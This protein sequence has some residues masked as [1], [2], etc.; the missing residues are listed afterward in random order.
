MFEPALGRLA[1]VCGLVVH[2]VASLSVRG[3]RSRHCVRGSSRLLAGLVRSL[4]D[5]WRSTD[6]SRFIAFALVVS[7]WPVAVFL[8]VS[9]PSDAALA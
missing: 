8:T 5:R 7:V 2:A 3:Q 4:C 9:G 1:L 6:R